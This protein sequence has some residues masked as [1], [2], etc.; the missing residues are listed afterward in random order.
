LEPRSSMVFF[1]PSDFSVPVL[2][3]KENDD[4]VIP[5]KLVAGSDNYFNASAG[6]GRGRSFQALL[7]SMLGVVFLFVVRRCTSLLCLYCKLITLAGS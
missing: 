2:M 4:M 7:L 5:V 6:T 3:L 1:T